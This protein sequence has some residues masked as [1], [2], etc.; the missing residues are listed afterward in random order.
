MNYLQNDTMAGFDLCTPLL[1]CVG[2]TEMLD[3]SKYLFT[4]LDEF[5]GYALR[6]D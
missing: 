2:V 1:H 5:F 3:M 4:S 6:N